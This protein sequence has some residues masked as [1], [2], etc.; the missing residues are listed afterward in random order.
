[1]L[2]LQPEPTFSAFEQLSVRLKTG[3][4]LVVLDNFEHVVAAA[5]ELAALLAA[6]HNST[7]WSPAACP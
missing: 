3:H 5:T 6:C 4:T 1:M 7:C 2:G